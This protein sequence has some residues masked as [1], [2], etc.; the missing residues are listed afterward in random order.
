MGC[1]HSFPLGVIK[2]DAI[3]NIF[4]CDF[5]LEF[6]ISFKGYIFRS[7]ITRLKRIND[8]RLWRHIGKFIFRVI[9]I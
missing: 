8:F 4:V 2:D 7:S 9:T 1:F 5:M 3:I 6:Q